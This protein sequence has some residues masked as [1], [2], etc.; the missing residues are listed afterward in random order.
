[1]GIIIFILGGIFI[2]GERKMKKEFIYVIVG[3]FLVILGGIF[4]GYM[5]IV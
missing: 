2:F 3:C 4:L 5:K 1:M